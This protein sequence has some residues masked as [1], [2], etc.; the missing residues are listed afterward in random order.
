M[1][2]VAEA[3]WRAL[4]LLKSAVTALKEISNTL[5]LQFVNKVSPDGNAKKGLRF[6]L[7][8]ATGNL[9]AEYFMPSS[10]LREFKVRFSFFNFSR[11]VCCFK[12]CAQGIS[13][14]RR[15]TKVFHAA[16]KN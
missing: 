11:L 2:V 4:F 9:L 16:A 5:K 13:I 12:H 14:A 8:D 10:E 15:P 3:K 6:R 1:V 7:K